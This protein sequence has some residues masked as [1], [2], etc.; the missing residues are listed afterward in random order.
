MVKIGDYELNN[1]YCMDCVEGMKNLPDASIDLVVTSPP[2]DSTRTYNG[3]SFDLHATGKQ[4]YRVV[5]DGGIVAMVIQDQNGGFRKKFD[6]FS[7]D[8]GLV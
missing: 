6:F 7:H 4:L 2:Y 8:C 3:F 1:I 5:K